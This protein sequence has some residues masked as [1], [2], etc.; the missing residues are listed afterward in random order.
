MQHRA[1]N[2]RR[3]LQ[4]FM[5]NIG[6]G[7]VSHAIKRIIYSLVIIALLPSS[8]YGY[9][10]YKESIKNDY[11]LSLY[12]TEKWEWT[13]D[14]TTLNQIAFDKS[15]GR[16]V[17]RRVYMSSNHIIYIYKN[18][19]F[20]TTTGVGFPAKCEPGSIVDA[21]QAFNDGNPKQLSCHPSGLFYYFSVIWPGNDRP[22][23]PWS[24]DFGRYK[25]TE[26]FDGW[27]FGILEKEFAI[28]QSSK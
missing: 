10:S 28:L 9:L 24:E 17:L 4:C 3:L 7:S 6:S 26:R 2:S 15:L 11:M 16:S 25:F 13:D 8:I 20:S 22:Y 5:F 21:K 14:N 12:T 19:D 23:L 18:D 27:P 1:R